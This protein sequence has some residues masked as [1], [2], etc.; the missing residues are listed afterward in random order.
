MFTWKWMI[1]NVAIYLVNQVSFVFFVACSTTRMFSKCLNL[2]ST[3]TQNYFN[4]FDD[5]K[6]TRSRNKESH[7]MYTHNIIHVKGTIYWLYM[8]NLLETLIFMFNSSQTAAKQPHLLPIWNN[9]VI[10]LEEMNITW[11]HIN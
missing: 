2:T 8:I 5:S 4:T 3:Y 6:L 9:A 11:F 7:T 10:I 1:F